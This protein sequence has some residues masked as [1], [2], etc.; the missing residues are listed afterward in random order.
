MFYIVDGVQEIVAHEKF[1]Q[2]LHKKENISFTW[3]SFNLPYISSYFINIDMFNS[4]GK[5]RSSVIKSSFYNMNVNHIQICI[6][7]S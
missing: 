6:T 2:L 7:I 3:K 5:N 4:F 1:Q